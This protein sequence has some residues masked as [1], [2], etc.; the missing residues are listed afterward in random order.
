[1]PRHWEPPPSFFGQFCVTPTT[2]GWHLKGN[3][4]DKVWG[5]SQGSPSNATLMLWGGYTKLSKKTYPRHFQQIPT[6][7]WKRPQPVREDGL[8]QCVLSQEP[9]YVVY[10]T[11]GSF[12]IP[13]VVMFA[14]YLKIFHVTRARARRS[15]AKTSKQPQHKQAAI[16]GLV[17]S[18]VKWP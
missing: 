13:L 16:V 15:L 11:V 7:G 2:L 14:V 12:Y 8:N 1:L 3:L 6:L 17:V 18:Q 10:S 5:N 4:G 9:G